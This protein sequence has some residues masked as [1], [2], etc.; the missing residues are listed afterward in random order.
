M[1]GDGWMVPKVL[2]VDDDPNIIKI[3]EHTLKN[4][5]IELASANSGLEALEILKKEQPDLIIL[6]IMMPP[7]IDGFETFQRIRAIAD[8]PVIMLTSRSDEID[9]VAGLRM[10]VDDYQTKPFS[11][12]ELALRIKAILRRTCGQQNNNNKEIIKIGKLEINKHSRL[13]L[14][15]EKIVE[16]TPKE[17][18]LLWVLAS[19]P[20]Q[21]FT[22]IQ[23]LGLVWDSTYYQDENTVMVHIR[24]LREKIEANPSQPDYIKTVW[25]IGYKFDAGK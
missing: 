6:D 3:V 16:L 7:G 1:Q 13:V 23:I 4:E 20:N 21:V 25:G 14:I 5:G 2:I 9:R 15:A 11:P 10:G 8:I 18:D 17:F 24:R 12:T 22:K 19:S